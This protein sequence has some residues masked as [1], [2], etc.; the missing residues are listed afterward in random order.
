MGTKRSLEETLAR[1]NIARGVNWGLVGVVGWDRGR[2]SRMRACGQ[3][4]LRAPRGS[5]SR[6]KPCV[7]RIMSDIVIGGRSIPCP[8][9]T[10]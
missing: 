6:G 2:S 7:T 3:Q 5:P 4:G 8:A 1:V 9:V 10:E